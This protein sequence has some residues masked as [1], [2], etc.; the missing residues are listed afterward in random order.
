MNYHAGWQY[1]VSIEL[2]ISDDG[3]VQGTANWIL[4]GVPEAESSTYGSKV[5]SGAAETL[6]GQLAGKSLTLQGNVQ[7]GGGIVEAS[8]WKIAIVLLAASAASS[9]EDEPDI[10]DRTVTRL[11]EAD[12]AVL[13]GMTSHNGHRTPFMLHR[14]GELPPDPQDSSAESEVAQP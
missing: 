10:E 4:T 13:R 6:S 3:A 14:T 8:A 7:D 12:D 11:S 1:D 9:D 2:T 5:G